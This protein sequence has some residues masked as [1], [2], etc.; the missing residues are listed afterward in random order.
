MTKKAKTY[1]TE[2]TDD[3]FY[4]LVLKYSKHYYKKLK[5]EQGYHVEQDDIFGELAERGWE[6]KIKFGQFENKTSS[7]KTY[8]IR[9]F[10]NKMANFRNYL[11]VR[12]RKYPM[13]R[14][15]EC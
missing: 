12:Q 5:M 7:I 6:A 15:L 10:I 3:E 9:A 4:A 11:H 2:I 8:I 13:S 14:I 1:K